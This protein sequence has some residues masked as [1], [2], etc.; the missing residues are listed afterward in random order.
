MVVID[1]RDPL[2]IIEQCW[3]GIDG[4]RA[5]QLALVGRWCRRDGVGFPWQGEWPQ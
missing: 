1:A 3:A 5:R 2:R 4:W